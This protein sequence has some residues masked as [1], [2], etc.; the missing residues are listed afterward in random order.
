MGQHRGVLEDAIDGFVQLGNNPVLLGCFL[1]VVACL[2]PG[3]LAGISITMNLS[4]V[5]RLVLNTGRPIIV[6]VVC[7]A[8]Q[9]QSFKY[10][11]LIGFIIMT[12]GVMIFSNI[13]S[14]FACLSDKAKAND[15]ANNDAAEVL[16]VDLHRSISNLNINAGDAVL[17]ECDP[18]NPAIC[19][20][21]DENLDE[22]ENLLEK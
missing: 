6:W 13:L 15:D 10:L 1:G 5:H 9:W 11:Q 4:A 16:P 19:N 2:I 3:T 20:N 22:F 8:V 12:L 18:E 21:L 7:L 17:V 14:I